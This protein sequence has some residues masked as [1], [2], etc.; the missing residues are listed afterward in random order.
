MQPYGKAQGDCEKMGLQMAKSNQFSKFITKKYGNN[1]FPK[2]GGTTNDYLCTTKEVGPEHKQRKTLDGKRAEAGKYIILYHVADVAGNSECKT[3]KRTV[4]VKDTLPPVI[5]LHMNRKFVAKDHKNA[6]KGHKNTKSY[7][8]PFIKDFLMAET[9]T[10]INGWVIAAV[11]SAVAGV[12]L[13]G[14]SATR[15]QVVIDV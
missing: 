4:I 3:P 11:G 15:K 12:A 8:N 6:N 2:K 1:F 13:L 10:S 7:S 14:F 9:Q 5:T